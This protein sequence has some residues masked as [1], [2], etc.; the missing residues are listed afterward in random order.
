MGLVDKNTNNYADAIK[1]LSTALSLVN[2]KSK[3]NPQIDVSLVEKASIYV[4]LIDTL[5]IV[6][7]ADEAA[8]VLEDATEELKGTPEEARYV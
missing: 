7:Q 8:K 1:A 6:G 5:N 2:I 3:D 4:E